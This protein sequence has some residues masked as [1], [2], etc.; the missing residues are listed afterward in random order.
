[1]KYW[2]T[3]D[4]TWELRGRGKGGVGERGEGGVG[5]R[6]KKRKVCCGCFSAS[7][8]CYVANNRINQINSS[9]CEMP[10]FMCVAYV[11]IAYGI[12]LK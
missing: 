10:P 7:S 1:M 4:N 8:N 11:L 6:E 2:Q 3:L 5:E 12:S 9:W